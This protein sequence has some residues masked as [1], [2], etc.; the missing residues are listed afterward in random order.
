MN[1]TDKDMK[2]TLSQERQ[3]PLFPYEIWRLI[4]DL[5]PKDDQRT[6]LAASRLLHDL[7]RDSLFSH[8]TI[9]FGLW[10]PEHHRDDLERA[11]YVAEV[12]LRNTRS[13][14][15]LR[16]IKLDAAFAKAVKKLSVR[17]CATNVISVYERQCLIDALEWLPNLTSFVYHGVYPLLHERTIEA[18]EKGSGPTLSEFHAPNFMAANWIR[19]EVFARFPRL[20]RLSLVEGEFREEEGS[21]A[22]TLLACRAVQDCVTKVAQNGMLRSLHIS[23]ETIRDLPV[24]LFSNLRELEIQGLETLAAFGLILRHC[25]SQLESLSLVLIAVSLEESLLEDLGS[26]PKAVP[27]LR[28]LKLMTADPYWGAVHRYSSSIPDFLAHKHLRRLDTN[29]PMEGPEGPPQGSHSIFF[30]LSPNL[31]ELEVLGMTYGGDIVTSADLKKLDDQLPLGLK[32]LLMQFEFMQNNVPSNEW[33]DLFRKRR[34][35]QYLHIIDYAGLLDLK[36]QILEDHPDSLQ[37]VGY[38]QNLRWIERD[39]ETGLPVYSPRWSY[40][41]VKFRDAE[42]YGCED[43]SWLLKHHDWDEMDD[44]TS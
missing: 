19:P 32:A 17:A 12:D 38:G 37:L 31:P 30:E 1:V 6:C 4:V 42:D 9:Y 34:S 13:W 43:W 44:D 40:E 15:V 28:S 2:S 18:L 20:Q 35:L 29:I 36:Q 41:K 21:P 33:I 22:S 11:R 5:L 14:E 26:D 16:Y 3:W 23:G 27:N 10:A 8:V 25:G 39:P 24:R 7:S